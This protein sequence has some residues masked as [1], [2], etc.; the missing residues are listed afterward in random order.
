MAHNLS[1]TIS[2]LTSGELSRIGPSLR[3][4]PSDD[5]PGWFLRATTDDGY[6][7]LIPYT[8]IPAE[9]AMAAA[10]A[11]ELDRES[12]RLCNA[13]ARV[14]HDHLRTAKQRREAAEAMIEKGKR[15]LDT[16]DREATS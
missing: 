13:V 14:H 16:L 3:A 10:D 8:R 11:L 5:Q 6:A 12:M 9:T 2:Y 7:N 1:I 15:I 4:N